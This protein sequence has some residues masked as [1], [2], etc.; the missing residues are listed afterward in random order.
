M[1]SCFPVR[2]AYQFTR[3]RP[4]QLVEEQAVINLHSAQGANRIRLYLAP[5]G[6][7]DVT[8][9]VTLPVALPS[10]RAI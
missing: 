9:A 4:E 5:C 2:L 10:D 3:H 8:P 6:S 7:F 1:S